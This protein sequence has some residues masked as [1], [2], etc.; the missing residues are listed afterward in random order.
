MIRGHPDTGGQPRPY[1][2]TPSLSPPSRAA[3]PAAMLTAPGLSPR[4]E[5]AGFFFRPLCRS[6]ISER[7]ARARRS[8][9]Y[10]AVP[11]THGARRGWRRRSAGSGSL[12]IARGWDIAWHACYAALQQTLTL[13]SADNAGRAAPSA[14]GFWP[15]A[16]RK[17]GEMPPSSGIWRGARP[18]EQGQALAAALGERRAAG[19]PLPQPQPGARPRGQGRGR[20]VRTRTH[21]KPRCTNLGVFS[22]NHHPQLQNRR[23]VWVGRDLDAHLLP[24]PCH[25]QG[26][27]P[28][29]QGAHSSI[30]PGLER[31]QGGGSHSSS[32]PGLLHLQSAESV[33]YLISISPRSARSH[34]PLPYH[35]LPM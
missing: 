33:F 12:A 28:P 8:A 17:A 25:E 5:G 34:D 30:Q 2:N 20:R 15:E 19:R 21:G 10:L 22:C 16:P 9:L 7:L 6:N 13:L 24:T 3:Q 32:G 4:P 18:A 29:A 14:A 11:C 35:S 23:T 31:C 26:H 1:R 27:L